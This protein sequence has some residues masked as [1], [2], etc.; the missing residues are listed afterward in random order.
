VAALLALFLGGLG[1]HHFYL[2]RPILGVLYL[3]FCWTFIPAIIAFIEGL[4][5]LV[6]SDDSF[7]RSHSAHF[8]SAGMASSGSAQQKPG[9]NGCVV[10]LVICGIVG[11]VGFVVLQGLINDHNRRRQAA[12][13]FHRGEA[14]RALRDAERMLDEL[15]RRQ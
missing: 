12:I 10:A 3:L 15:R 8:V 5:L 14:D 6:T 1:A 2:G 9:G 13:D 4:V 7:N 11:L